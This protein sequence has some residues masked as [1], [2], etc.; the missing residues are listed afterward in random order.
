[1]PAS[2]IQLTAFMEDGRELRVDIDQ[3]DMAK[4]EI[5]PEAAGETPMT[6]LRFLAWSAAYRQRL[7]KGS[8]AEWNADDCVA[9]EDG[10]GGSAEDVESLDPGRPDTSG[11]H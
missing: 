6:R 8:F 4:W 7:Y 11:A 2:K 3:R 5:Q 1:M 9:V 10:D